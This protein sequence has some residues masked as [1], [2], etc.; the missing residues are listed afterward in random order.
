MRISVSRG[1]HGSLKSSTAYASFSPSLA[2]MVCI[3]VL[4]GIA[5]EVLLFRG[6]EQRNAVPLALRLSR[7]D[8][9]QLILMSAA[10]MTFFHLTISWRM[11]AANSSD[12]PPTIFAPLNSI[13]VRIS[14][15]RAR[16]ATSSFESRLT[17]ASGVPAR[18]A[19]PCHDDDS[20]PGYP[21][22]ATVFTSGSALER[23][24]EVTAIARRRPDFTCGTIR[25]GGNVAIG[26]CPATRSVTPGASPL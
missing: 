2:V 15:L 22:S 6:D 18:T 12:V 5:G 20:N 1:P 16:S 8:A 23:S 21:D 17:I 4:K 26:M 9:D 24:P 7:H 11:Y 14:W 13:V 19:M 10:A 25:S 3:S